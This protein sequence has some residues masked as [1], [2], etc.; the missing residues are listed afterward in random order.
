LLCRLAQAAFERV[1]DVQA[2][3]RADR[4]RNS[5]PAPAMPTS[6]RSNAGHRCAPGA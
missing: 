5:A 1:R 3:R 4:S 6:A 2:L